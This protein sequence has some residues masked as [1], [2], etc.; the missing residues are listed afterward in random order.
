M[1]LSD[2]NGSKTKAVEY[3]SKKFFQGLADS[4]RQYRQFIRKKGMINMGKASGDTF[5]VSIIGDLPLVGSIAEN[6]VSPSADPSIDKVSVT[7]F[8]VASKINYTNKLKSIAELPIEDIFRNKLA[9][10]AARSLDK[11]AHD[12]VFAT[13]NLVAT[14]VSATTLEWTTDGTSVGNNQFEMSLEHVLAISTY[15]RANRMP[16]REGNIYCVGSP[17]VLASIQQKLTDASLAT[18]SGFARFVKGIVGQIYGIMFV[19]ENNVNSKD[20]YF[21]GDEV[22][23]EVVVEPEHI[24]IG[25]ETDIGRNMEIGWRYIGAF[26]K[27]ADNR[28]IKFVGKQ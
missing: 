20:A 27:I 16:L 26:S 1:F 23:L 13:T 7:V 28:I 6:Q 12:M 10:Q 2:A 21:F 9:Q 14:P 19:T 5:T 4:D 3:F 22:G 25:T 15:M 24:V 11:M 8:E 18:E 17:N